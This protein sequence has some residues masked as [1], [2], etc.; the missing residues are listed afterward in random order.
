M[1]LINLQKKVVMFVKSVEGLRFQE[2]LFINIKRGAGYIMWLIQIADIHNASK[3]T[4]EK[5]KKISTEMAIVINNHVKENELLVFVICG[6]IIN[7][8]KEHGFEETKDFLNI[9]TSKI[10]SKNIKYII[11]PG[12][13]DIV[14]GLGR[15][16]FK[17]LDKFIFDLSLTSEVSFQKDSV[18]I[19]SV[20]KIDFLIINSS[21]H[22]NQNY[23]KIDLEKL[24]KVLDISENEEKVIVLHH[25]L[26]PMREGENSTVVNTYEFLKMLEGYKILAILHGHQH[27]KIEMRMGSDSYQIIGVGSILA[28]IETNYNNQF[29]LIKIDEKKITKKL[30]FKFTMEEMGDSAIGKFIEKKICS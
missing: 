24:K 19:V 3:Y 11:C 12:N 26:I 4:M 2:I 8:G 6:D 27:M 9:I 1:G 28:N 14:N 20:N 23:G 7:Q 15:K 5:M 16:S 18:N 21:Y 30:E 17:E 29:N 10:N 13:H 25:H 22:F